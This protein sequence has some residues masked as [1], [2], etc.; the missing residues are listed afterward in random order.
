MTTLG[1][2]RLITAQ[3]L[4]E[5]GKEEPS[6]AEVVPMPVGAR[7]RVPERFSAELVASVLRNLGPSVLRQMGTFS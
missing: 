7:P 1:V 2:R 4:P 3:D 6:F 5:I